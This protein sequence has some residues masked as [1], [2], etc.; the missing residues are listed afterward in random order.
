M[1]ALCGFAIWALISAEISMA[2]SVVLT[3]TLGIIVDDTVHFLSKY[4]KAIDA[5]KNAQDAIVFA[6]ENVG[7]ALVITTLVLASG[8]A[9][10]ALSDFA[11]N[12]DMGTLTAIIIVIALIV[13]LLLLPAL[14]NKLSAKAPSQTSSAA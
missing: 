8:F 11:I 5:G 10:L 4:K 1:P 9:V 14:L 6:F 12:S 7:N 13:D 2:L 3:M